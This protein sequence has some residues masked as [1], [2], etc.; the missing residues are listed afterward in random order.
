MENE[1]TEKVKKK[2]LNEIDYKLHYKTFYGV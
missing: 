2:K 1:K